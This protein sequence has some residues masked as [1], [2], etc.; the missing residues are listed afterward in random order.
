MMGD[1]LAPETSLAINFQEDNV[2]LIIMI[3]YFHKPSYINLNRKGSEITMN[4][5]ETVCQEG[6]IS[7]AA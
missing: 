5:L 2:R 1:V 6:G 3:H 7:V 4:R